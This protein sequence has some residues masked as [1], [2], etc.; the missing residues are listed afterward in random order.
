MAKMSK[1]AGL[2][3]FLSHFNASRLTDLPDDVA[4]LVKQGRYGEAAD[5]MIAQS[6]LQSMADLGPQAPPPAYNPDAGPRKYYPQGTG[7]IVRERPRPVASVAVN[8]AASEGVADAVGKQAD[9]IDRLLARVAPLSPV[10]MKVDRKNFL[11][12]DFAIDDT[13]GDAVRK[14]LGYGVIPGA[15]AGMAARQLADDG[16]FPAARDDQ[17]DEQSATP[18]YP[19]RRRLGPVSSSSRRK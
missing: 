9:F 17:E 6:R 10:S 18:T 14:I 12:G 11:P 19:T 8:P 1:K 13:A 7:M 3:S 4:E 16:F 5:A 15:T 2:A